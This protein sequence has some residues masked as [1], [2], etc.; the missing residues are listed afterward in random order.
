MSTTRKP[1]EAVNLD[2]NAL[3]TKAQEETVEKKATDLAV[4]RRIA[5][6]V[7]T[8]SRAQLIEGDGGSPE[9]VGETLLDMV[10]AVEAFR[11]HA[12]DLQEIAE[13]AWARLMA[14]L[15][16]MVDEGMVE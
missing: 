1:E 4:N 14:S 7:L 13:A 8:R 11:D 16:T 9:D 12:K 3:L 2:F 5:L 6:A 15:Q 10:G